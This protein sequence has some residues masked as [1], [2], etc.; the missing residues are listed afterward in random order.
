MELISLRYFP[1]VKRF[2]PVEKSARFRSS[3]VIFCPA[4][5]S[6][7]RPTFEFLPRVGDT[8][9]A[10]AANN[11]SFG[12]VYGFRLDMLTAS[13]S[14][15]LWRRGRRPLIVTLPLCLGPGGC[16]GGT[17]PAAHKCA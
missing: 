13:F 11:S 16:A 6:S 8:S 3:P 7:L 4:C 10:E 12:G 17:V 2:L 1:S 14:C 15:Q 9:G 5:S